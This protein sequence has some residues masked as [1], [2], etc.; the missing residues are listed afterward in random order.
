MSVRV[1][2]EAEER[3]AVAGL[4]AKAYTVTDGL[5]RGLETLT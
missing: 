2:W 5:N 4:L 3:E 1:A